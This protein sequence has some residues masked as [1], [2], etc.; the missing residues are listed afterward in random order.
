MCMENNPNNTDAPVTKAGLNAEFGYPWVVRTDAPE[1]GGKHMHDHSPSTV[2][3]R[4]ILKVGSFFHSEKLRTDGRLLFRTA[5]IR[6][7]RRRSHNST[8]Y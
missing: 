7:G 5:C 8:S 6:F 4:K 3:V 2:M 1:Q